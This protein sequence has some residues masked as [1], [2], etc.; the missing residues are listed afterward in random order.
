MSD[1][2]FWNELGNIFNAVVA[3]QRKTIEFN[4]RFVNPWIRLGTVFDQDDHNAESVQAYRKAIE[5][6]PENASNWLS[7]GD[8]YF[9]MSSLDDAVDAYN[10]AIEL[11]PK[12]GWAYANLALTR[13]AQ[14]KYEDAINLFDKSLEF[15]TDEK[16]RAIIWNRLGNVYRKVNDYSNAFIAFQKADECDAQNTGFQDTLDEVTV[17]QMIMPIAAAEAFIQNTAVSAESVDSKVST[18]QAVIETV[19]SQSEVTEVEEPKS[20]AS[21]E[22][23]LA[24]ATIENVNLQSE[25]VDIEESK[26]DSSIEETATEG[27]DPA[28][29]EL[30]NLIQEIVDSELGEEEPA[31]VF[32]DS[33]GTTLTPISLHLVETIASTSELTESPVAEESVNEAN[34]LETEVDTQVQSEAVDAH[35]DE[36]AQPES[37]AVLE[38]PEA[39]DTIA[40]QPNNENINPLVA[41]TATDTLQSSEIADEELPVES[42]ETKPTPEP[43]AE[44]PKVTLKVEPDSRNAHVWNELGNV[45]FNTGSLDEAIAVYSRA[46]ELDDAFAWPYSNLALAYVQKEKY[47]EAILLYQRSIELFVSDQDKAITWNRLGNVYRRLNDYDNAIVCY[48]RADDLDPNNATRSLRSRFSLLGNLNIEQVSSLVI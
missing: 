20:E 10:K 39:V 36:Q 12:F 33:T 16:D 40:S 22:E 14:Q 42:S 26:N 5:I 18:A 2:E 34:P 37:A 15:I 17:E 6:D 1:Y 46:I 21:I 4:K 3:Y 35:I 43:V 19:N 38:S 48:Q 32:E 28:K 13:A 41:D 31:V 47:A 45:Y 25:V 11:N 27:D 24:E 9:K 7:L 44:M 30:L 23:I 29:A 8:V